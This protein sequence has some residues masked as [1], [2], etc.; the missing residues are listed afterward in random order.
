MNRSM[1]HTTL[2]A[3]ACAAAMSGCTS[4]APA[5]QRPD[6]PV[7]ASFGSTPSVA[8]AD[9]PVPVARLEWRSVFIDPQLQQVI[10]LALDNNRD[11]RVAMLNIEA[12]RAKYRIQRADLLPSVDATASNTTGTGSQVSRSATAQVGFS[13]WEL[14]LFGRIRSLKD[15]ALQTWLATEQTQ[16]STRMSLVAEVAGNWLTVGA[17][18][19]RLKLA[20][21]TLASQ[22]ESLALTERRHEQ[23]VMSGV[24]LASLQASVES[25]RADVAAYTTSLAQARNALELVVGT[26]VSDDQLPAATAGTTDAV[27]LAPLPAEVSS[28]VLL[29]RPDVLY[30]EHTLK[31]ANADI[32]AARAAFFPTISLTAST[33]SGSDALSSLFDS[34]T[35]QWSFAPTISLP[36]FHAGALK[37]SLDQAKIS[38]DVSVAQ[39][40]KAIQSAFSEVADAL[41]TR[42]TVDEQRDAQQARVAATTR[43]R[44]LAEVRYRNGIDSRLELLD[45]QRTDDAAQQDLVT[46]RLAEAT[47]R[48]TLYKVLGGGADALA[49]SGGT[50]ATEDQPL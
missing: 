34:G 8:V 41:A 24:D 35:K 13:S 21:Q 20:E 23:G 45:A 47:N 18:Q 5:Y 36:I 46:L 29:Q 42:A 44:D 30:A 38:K 49:G 2:L 14:D 50:W 40:E 1:I 32:G 48:V 22:R 28:A 10:A 25:A 11:L 33:G 39:Y 27:A 16:R 26:A 12:A 6:A 3:L 43:A 31:A 9:E 7:R 37:A 17:Y 15:E 19:Q 4:M